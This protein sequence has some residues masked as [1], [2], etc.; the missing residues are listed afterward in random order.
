MYADNDYKFVAVLNEKFA[1]PVLMNAFGHMTAG[2]ITQCK[3]INAFRFLRY[4]DA[5][6]EVHPA[7]SLCPF[8]VLAAMNGNQIRTLRLVAIVVDIPYND[9]VDTMLGASAEDQLQ[10]TRI[11]REK[12]LKYIGICLFGPAER[13]NGMTRK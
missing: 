4:E 7:I 10:K 11:T 12:D 9:F 1:L 8:I 2:L 13:L 6:R 5:D 3:D